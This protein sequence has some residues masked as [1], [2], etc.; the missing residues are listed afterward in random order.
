MSKVI[1]IHGL[2]GS[3]KTT[4]SRQIAKLLGAVHINADWAR[5]TVT[6]H[7]GFG[8]DDRIRQARTLGQMSRMVFEQ[9]PWVVVDFVCPTRETRYAFY[10]TFMNRSNVYS[11]WMNTIEKGRFEDT[12]R[13]YQKPG[14]GA[15]D[16]VIEGYQSQEQ[17]RALAQTV[18]DTATG[19][20]A[21]RSFF[22]RYNTASDGESKQW[23][24]IDALTMKETLVDDFEIRGH[25]VPGMTVEHQV[26]KWN[27]EVKGHGSFHTYDGNERNKFIL[28]Y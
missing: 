23:R 8:P 18:A 12:N 20:A 26:K 28:Q 3:G 7:L 10:D 17:L 25:M 11:V 16:F 19:L 4:I 15:F 14:E 5:E 22:I 21:H 6:K 27:V 2:P 24:V 1:L 9:G 13:L